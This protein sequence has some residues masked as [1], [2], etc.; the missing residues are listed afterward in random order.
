MEMLY[1]YIW[2]YGLAGT[3]LRTI[4]GRRVEVLR[5]GRHNSDA[6]P[7]FTG[8]RLR[9]DGVEWGGNVEVHV[10]ASDWFRHHHEE[11]TAYSNV[12]LHVV[13]ISDTR[14]P[15]GRGSHIPQTLIT[16]P[17]SFIRLYGRLAEK[18]KAVTC[19]DM[20]GAL[21]P[22]VVSDWLST[23]T[24][25][26]MQVKARR[27]TDTYELLGHDWEWTCFAALARALG[28][29]LN[30]EPLEIL[31][32]MVPPRLL[33]KHSD[34]MQQLEALLMGQAGLLDPA[35]NIYDTY[36]QN[37]CREYMFL[38]RKYQLRPMRRDI[39][40]FSRTRPQN[41]PT[42]RIAILARAAADGFS[43]LSRITSRSFG[44]EE[45][46]ELF[47]WHLDGY[48]L[49]HFDFGVPGT[50]LPAALSKNNIDLL[51]INFVAPL[52]YAYGTVRCDPDVAERG[53]DL[54]YGLDAENNGIIRQWRAAGLPAACAADSQAML[55][56][57]NEYCERHRC[58]ECRFGHALL[59]RESRAVK[60][61]YLTG[62]QPEEVLF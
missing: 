39:W 45:A 35:V 25:E 48:W 1:Q 38:S 26:R 9:I 23:L 30:S 54:W 44:E 51:L 8:A 3:D 5:P 15:D 52:L 7:D 17:E 4:D 16:F 41:F 59:R 19:E 34:N 10:R 22:L 18:I 12:I 21:P 42:R 56:L 13:G 37:L 29:G 53:L 33:S 32:R 47:G 50:R 11:D 62:K 14:V 43:L 28:F 20:L 36:Y 2:K 31:A 27:I 60:S 6:G 58:L 49:E 61:V 24:V 46:R 57:R 55:Q 40:K